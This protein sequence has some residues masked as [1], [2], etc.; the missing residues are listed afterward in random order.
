MSPLSSCIAPLSKTLGSRLYENV[1]TRKCVCVYIDIYAYIFTYIVLS[2][3][4]KG[5]G[6]E[7]SPALSHEYMS[8]KFFLCMSYNFFDVI[9]L[10]HTQKKL[11]WENQN[12]KIYMCVT[13]S[14]LYAKQY[15]F[16]VKINKLQMCSSQF[17]LTRMFLN[18][19]VAC[20]LVL[21]RLLHLLVNRLR[22]VWIDCL[23][24]YR[25]CFES[26]NFSIF[27]SNF[28]VNNCFPNFAIDFANYC[29]LQ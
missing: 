20:F 19:F 17:N 25:V 14:I 18:S 6:G 2:Q 29:N 3:K 21:M 13:C 10:H 26:H 7:Y 22:V 1:C 11:K 12:R 15:L 24:V 16:T 5:P 28:F 23:Y 9:C 27:F 8:N 4:N